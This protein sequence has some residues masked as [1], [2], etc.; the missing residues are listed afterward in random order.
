MNKQSKPTSK[1]VQV[2]EIKD[3]KV[4]TISFNW[5]LSD[6]NVEEN[7]KILK[8]WL[9]NNDYKVIS[10]PIEAAYNGPMTLPMFRK[11]EIFIEVEK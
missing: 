4:A 6:S 9:A 3:Y 11:N 2:N 7:T 8:N 5:T 10:K 1:D